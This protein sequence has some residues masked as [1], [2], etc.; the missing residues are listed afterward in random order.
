MKRISKSTKKGLSL[1]ELIVVVVIM[2]II[3]AAVIG[4]L[5]YKLYEAQEFVD[6]L[7]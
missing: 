1:A 3:L 7:I 5:A 2:V 4:V 6:G